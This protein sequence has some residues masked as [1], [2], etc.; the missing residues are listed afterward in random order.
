MESGQL[1]AVDHSV[2]IIQPS[3]NETANNEAGD[4][5]V[6]T[7]TYDLYICYNKYYQTPHLFLIGFDEHRKMLSMEQM[8]EDVSQDNA[9]KT[10]TME[11]HP[12][13]GLSLLAVHPCRHSDLMK[14]FIQIVSLMEFSYESALTEKKS[15]LSLGRGGRK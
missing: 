2:A 1:E 6:H 15:F 13:L 3:Q 5:I 14:K 8:F 9:K 10:V 12:H 4:S 7:R 11:S